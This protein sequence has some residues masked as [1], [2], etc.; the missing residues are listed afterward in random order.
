MTNDGQTIYFCSNNL[1]SVG[2]FD[3][4]KSKFQGESGQWTEPVNLGLPINSSANEYDIQLEKKGRQFLFTSDRKKNGTGGKD[5]YIGYPL[6]ELYEQKIVS[7]G[8]ALNI[9]SRDAPRK[10]SEI[11][12]ETKSEK[13]RPNLPKTLA[14]SPV[15]LSYD[16]VTLLADGHTDRLEEVR[17]NLRNDTTLGVIIIG[18]AHERGARD[19]NLYFS[20][21]KAKNVGDAL[22]KMGVAR[23]SI[24]VIGAGDAQ[25]LLSYRVNGIVNRAASKW[26]EQVSLLYY[27]KGIRNSLNERLFRSKPA[28]S[29]ILSLEDWELFT[30]GL[31]YTVHFGSSSQLISF[32]Q[33]HEID[34]K[35]WCY[36]RKSGEL[37]NYCIGIKSSFQKTEALWRSLPWDLRRRARIVAFHGLHEVKKE[38]IIDIAERNRDVLLYLKYL[39]G[40]E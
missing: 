40:S 26:N 25:T 1:N 38:D 19:V 32:D 18:H 31:F 36:Y 5:I 9:L 7:R 14:L 35:T 4:F 30:N 15:R 16:E 28:Q 6:E 39:N 2:G 37:I 33:L 17:E 34:G 13:E 29:R 8:S 24:E 23:G 21:K 11:I 12:H 3:I 27:K 22:I 10:K 20:V